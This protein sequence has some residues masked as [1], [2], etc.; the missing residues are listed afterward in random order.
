ME[1]DKTRHSRLKVFALVVLCMTQP[2]IFPAATAIK[3]IVEGVQ[4]GQDP[5]LTVA[6][7]FIAQ[8][9]LTLLD[10]LFPEDKPESYGCE[11]YF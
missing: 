8:R 11:L 9:D 2:A 4:T 1:N 3:E 6:D 5:F 7:I 10:S